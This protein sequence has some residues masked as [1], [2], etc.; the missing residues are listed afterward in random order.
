MLPT[1][2]VHRLFTP[3]VRYELPGRIEG[4]RAFVA[5]PESET[6]APRGVV[7]PV[8]LAIGPEGGFIEKEIDTFR[9]IG[10]TPISVGRRILRVETALP[11]L[12]ARLLP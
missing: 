1:I 8:V 7:E 2:R 9:A 12:I 6:P 10:F 3:F 11:Y 4:R 5:H